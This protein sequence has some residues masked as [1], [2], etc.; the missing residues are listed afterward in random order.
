MSTA[1]R[2]NSTHSAGRQDLRTSQVRLLAGSK[3]I[4][5]QRHLHD[6]RR[7][8]RREHTATGWIPEPGSQIGQSVKER[9]H[10]SL[11]VAIVGLQDEIGGIAGKI[12]KPTEAQI[13]GVSRIDRKHH[14]T[15]DL[16]NRL[17]YCRIINLWRVDVGVV[18]DQEVIVLQFGQV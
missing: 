9:A 3:R 1:S 7:T 18:N 14:P 17:K 4:T 16:A 10:R 11:T 6:C 13:V 8:T 12:A 5:R 15:S 2:R